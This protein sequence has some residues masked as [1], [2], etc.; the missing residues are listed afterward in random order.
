MTAACAQESETESCRRPCRYEKY[1]Q[2]V[3]EAAAQLSQTLRQQHPS[4]PWTDIISMRN[5]LVHHYFG[6]DFNEIWDT[7]T[8]DL[9]YLK[10]N[11]DSILQELPEDM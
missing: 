7:V 5:V 10:R 9:P 11:V 3:G 8:I 4:I 6:I 2:I 1:I